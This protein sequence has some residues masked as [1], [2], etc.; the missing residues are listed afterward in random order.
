MTVI[1]KA[2]SDGVRGSERR[3]AGARLPAAK[4]IEEAKGS[5]AGGPDFPAADAGWLPDENH[6]HDSQEMGCGRGD[7]ERTRKRDRGLKPRGRVNSGRGTYI[8]CIRSVVMAHTS[9]YRP[10][11]Q[12]LVK[13][14]FT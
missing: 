4:T 2:V 6:F 8:W 10:T 1:D 12:Q 14:E 9:E 11:I 3:E 13:E 7:V 5:E